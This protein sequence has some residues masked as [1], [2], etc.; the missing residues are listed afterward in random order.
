ME[1]AIPKNRDAPSYSARRAAGR[2]RR[3]ACATHRED[4][5]RFGARD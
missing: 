5:C 1:R 3:V 4:G 2:D